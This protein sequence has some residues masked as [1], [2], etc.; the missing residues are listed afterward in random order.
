M[1]RLCGVEQAAAKAVILR[2]LPL[3][4][5]LQGVAGACT[6]LPFTIDRWGQETRPEWLQVEFQRVNCPASERKGV[7]TWTELRCYTTT[8]TVLE[9]AESQALKFLGAN[10]Q[11][12]T[13]KALVVQREASEDQGLIT[14]RA[15]P[16]ESG[17]SLVS[18]HHERTE[19]EWAETQL[20]QV[21]IKAHSL[22]LPAGGV[23]CAE[24]FKLDARVFQSCQVKQISAEYATTLN[25]PLPP[26][27]VGWPFAEF[28]LHSLKSTPGSKTLGA[29][30]YAPVCS[31]FKA[32]IDEKSYLAVWVLA[33]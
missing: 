1:K 26:N 19:R 20:T 24:L 4:L 5:A 3:L 15:V 30:R 11:E 10:I 16:H 21:L 2:S 25:S 17:G 22:D 23:S 7:T 9:L 31:H 14:V 33:W 12:Q 32:L 29:Y 18:Y 13:S 27:R 28:S 6:P 8:R